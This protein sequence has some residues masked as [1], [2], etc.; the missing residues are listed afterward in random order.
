[1]Q[2]LKH[3]ICQPQPVWNR[4]PPVRATVCGI[5]I[6][7]IHSASLKLYSSSAVWMSVI[8]TFNTVIFALTTTTDRVICLFTH[9]VCLNTTCVYIASNNLIHLLKI[10][11]LSWRSLC[12]FFLCQLISVSLWCD[13]ERM[14]EYLL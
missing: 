10:L 9:H 5:M 6:T 4:F 8:E 1:M 7:M 12:S 11:L 3:I 14:I 2:E 13:V